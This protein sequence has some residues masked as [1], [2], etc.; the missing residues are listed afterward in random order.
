[1]P[2]PLLLLFEIVGTVAF[3]ISGA[4]TGMKKKMDIFGVAILGLTTAVGGGALRDIILGNTPPV[5]FRNP[6]Y[7][8]IAIVTSV[9]LFLP[10]VQRLILRIHGLYDSLMLLMDS[11][12]LGIFTVVGIR[13]AY[14]A[15]A[16]PGWFLLLFVGVVT[17][18]GGGVLRDVMAGDTPYVFV[19]HFYAC[20]S[21]L[22][23]VVCILLWTLAGQTIAMA[24]GAAAVVALRYLAVK[25]RWSLPKA[26]CYM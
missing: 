9:I 8:V 7:A 16:D 25:Y 17:G 24:A 23:A 12:G 26:R 11:V 22:G 19:K 3:A 13:T 1:M 4:M 21:L 18:V 2:A 6:I 15:V 14:A 20:A 10:A 5:M